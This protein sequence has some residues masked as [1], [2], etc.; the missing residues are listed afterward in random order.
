[1]PLVR[2]PSAFTCRAE[3]LARARASPHGSIHRPSG[4]GQGKGPSANPGEKVALGVSP[5]L[6]WSNILNTPF[7][8]I[9]GRYV[10]RC[11]QVP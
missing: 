7:I 5:Q 6:A 8:N 2:K 11:Y 3:R 1:M 10:S 9:A 4:N